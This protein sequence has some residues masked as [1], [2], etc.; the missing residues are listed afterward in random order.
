MCITLA[1]SRTGNIQMPPFQQW[2]VEFVS[3]LSATLVGVAAIVGVA[4]LWKWR[5]ETIGKAR[6]Q[7]A[8]NM[9]RLTLQFRAEFKSARNPLTLPHEWADR[10]RDDNE[11]PAEGNVLNEFFARGKRLERLSETILKLNELGWEVEVVLS[12]HD[13]KLIQPFID[14]YMKL[15]VSFDS[16]FRERYQQAKNNPVDPSYILSVEKKVYGSDEDDMSRAVDHAVD[17]TKKQ[18]KKYILR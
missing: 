16:Y 14:S 15:K 11:S 4:G 12:E 9:I 7:V 18:L 1:R 17:A 3:M 2:F 5:S 13:A 8:R 10:K 6:F